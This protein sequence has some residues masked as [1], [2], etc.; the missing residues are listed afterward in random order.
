LKLWTS[1]YPYLVL[2]SINI[3][4]GNISLAENCFD[5][6]INLGAPGNN[7]KNENL[8]Y[9]GQVIKVRVN[10]VTAT[11]TVAP[12]ST[13]SLFTLQPTKPAVTTTP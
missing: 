7:I 11:P 3:K 12:T 6:A 9:V 13:L 10:L 1:F 8:I 5:K 4:K 2:G